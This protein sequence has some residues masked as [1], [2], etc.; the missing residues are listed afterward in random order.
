MML[1]LRN[2]NISTRRKMAINLRG[3]LLDVLNSVN[4]V[5]RVDQVEVILLPGPVFVEVIDFELDVGP[6]PGGLDGGAER[7]SWLE[8]SI[9]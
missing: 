8:G 6:D 2:L 7:V 9:R 1:H 3:Q 5:A 4:D